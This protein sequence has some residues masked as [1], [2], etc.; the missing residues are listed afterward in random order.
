MTHTLHRR[1]DIDSLEEDYIL[2]IYPARGVN[3]DGS[4]EKMKQIWDVISHYE[5]EL[6][7]FGNMDN[8]NSHQTSIEVHKKAK[9]IGLSMQFLRI[10]RH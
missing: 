2:I 5:R 4:E 1:G 3:L 8:G 7:N 9:K 10:R 6:V